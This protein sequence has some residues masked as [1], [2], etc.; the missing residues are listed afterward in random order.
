V[1]VLQAALCDAEA[2]VKVKSARSTQQKKRCWNLDI[3]LDWVLLSASSWRG[4][5]SLLLGGVEE[6][7]TWARDCF[8]GSWIL[9]ALV[10]AIASGDLWQESLGIE[11]ES[12]AKSVQMGECRCRQ[13]LQQ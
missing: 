6:R 5:A 1:A 10:E 4:R 11:D 9:G 7:K 8:S 12:G 2:K 13:R 3:L